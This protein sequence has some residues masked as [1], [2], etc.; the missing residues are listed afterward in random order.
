MWNFSTKVHVDNEA[1]LQL[2]GGVKIVVNGLGGF[3]VLI[4]SSHFALR[5][6]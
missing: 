6:V 4:V 1:N 3:E 2:L 5:C